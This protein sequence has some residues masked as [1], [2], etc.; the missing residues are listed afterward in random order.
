MSEKLDGIGAYWDGES[1][2]SR[3]GK[4]INNPSENF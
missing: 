3:S 1:L 4:P 2:Y